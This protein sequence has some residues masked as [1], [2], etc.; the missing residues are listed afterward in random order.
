MKQ[1]AFVTGAGGCVGRRLVGRLLDDGWE[2]TA[3]LLEVE[4]DSFEFRDRS[5]VNCVIGGIN[6][7][8][9][10]SM[11]ESSVVFHLAAQVHT[12]PKTAEQREQ[13]FVVNRDGSA[14]RC[15]GRRP[16]RRRGVRL[17]LD[18]RRLRPP[19]RRAGLR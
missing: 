8:S 12:V 19:D 9:P 7:L 15:G 16:A 11:P 10:E 14:P 6:D 17:H 3:L 1:S 18:D 2:V 4:A 13:F 5:G